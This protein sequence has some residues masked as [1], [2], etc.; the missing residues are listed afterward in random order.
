[1]YFETVQNNV[2]KK[3]KKQ[4]NSKI[5]QKKRNESKTI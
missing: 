3:H 5:I 1:M 4:N 2:I